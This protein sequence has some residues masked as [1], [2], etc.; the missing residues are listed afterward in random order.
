MIREGTF[1]ESPINGTAMENGTYQ[2]TLLDL[3]SARLCEIGGPLLNFLNL[4][5]F[6]FF[7]SGYLRK[8]KSYHE[9]S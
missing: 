2:T 7:Y 6:H 5:Q 3:I 4:N 8:F 9:W 1:L